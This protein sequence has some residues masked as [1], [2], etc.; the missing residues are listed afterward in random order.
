MKNENQ[1]NSRSNFGLMGWLLVIYCFATFF[2]TSFLSS[3]LNIVSGIFAEVNGWSQTYLMSLVS[4]GGWIGVLA[5]YLAG[6]AIASGKVKIRPLGG[7][8]AVVVGATTLFWGYTKNLMVFTFLF[9]AYQVAYT[10]WAQMANQTILNNWFPRKKGLAIGWATTGFPLAAGPGVAL[11]AIM[12]GKIGFANCFLIVGI[13]VIAVGIIGSLLFTEYPEQR[14]CYPDNDKTM[15]SEQAAAELEAGRKLME[16]SPWTTRR[17]LS[18]KEVWLL[19]LASGYM[20]MFASGSILQVVPR[21]MA[22]GYDSGSA[23]GMLTVAALCALPGSY[24]CGLLD[25]KL[26]T[27][28]AVIITCA[29]AACACVLYCIP[30]DITIWIALVLIGASLGGTSNF[31]MSLTG[32]YFGRYNFQ[33]A[34]GTVLCITQLVGQSGAALIAVLASIWNYSVAYMVLAVLGLIATVLMA[35]VKDDFVAKREAQFAAEAK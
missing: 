17:L 6:L 21:L 10:L 7:V 35:M 34:F 23:T 13:I 28:A 25:T 24:L 30:N 20:L 22:I 4:I 15:T 14:N 1:I 11:F 5:V 18:T 8:S 19:S 12:M 3:S 32:T 9:I 33:K 16:Q 2:L 27:K 26:G 31:T 29:I